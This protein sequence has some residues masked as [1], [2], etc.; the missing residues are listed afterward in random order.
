MKKKLIKTG[1]L[2]AFVGLGIIGFNKDFG[3][4][5]TSLATLLENVEGFSQR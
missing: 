1:I 4:N 2:I 3:K 5:E